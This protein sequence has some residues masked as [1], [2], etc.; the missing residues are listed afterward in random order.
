MSRKERWISEIEEKHNS[1]ESYIKE[2][3][4]GGAEPL[5]FGYA[6]FLYLLR[7]G[8][9]KENDI[10]RTNLQG[11]HIDGHYEITAK[12]EL[13]GVEAAK[14]I[15]SGK[16]GVYNPKKI[17]NIKNSDNGWALCLFAKT[18]ILLSE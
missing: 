16:S 4:K 6:P 15:Y 17:L 8:L 11:R 3:I 18:R 5:L 7:K 13:K 9:L 1:L 14:G 2:M 10:I 12:G